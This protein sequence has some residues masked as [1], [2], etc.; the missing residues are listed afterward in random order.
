M[1]YKFIPE[2]G[3]LTKTF[4]DEFIIE[5]L[6]NKLIKLDDIQ[7]ILSLK[8]SEDKNNP[9]YF[10]Q[11]YNILGEKPIEILITKF[12]KKVLN[13]NEAPWFRDEFADLGDLDYHVKGQ[14]NFWLDIMGGGQRYVGGQ[15]RLYN[16]HLLIKNIM[17]K[18]GA[19][20]WM[21]HMEETLKE[22]TIS[23]EFKDKRIFVCIYD[24]LDF[25]MNKYSIEFD[26]NFYNFLK[27]NI[28]IKSKI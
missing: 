26:F 27:K 3:F 2:F 6:I 20:R 23:P 17:T 11:L 4:R 22:I 21:K 19:E 18:R 5:Q 28:H 7:Q 13:D 1:L 9:I 25:F 24:F 12:Y 8:A 14:T 15:K 10:W 16:K